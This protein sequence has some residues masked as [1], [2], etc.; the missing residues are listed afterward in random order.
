M[1]TIVDYLNY[2][3]LTCGGG[4][5][6]LGWL[7]R[8]VTDRR[9]VFIAH[10]YMQM[11]NG[12]PRDAMMLAQV[13]Y[14]ADIN[15]E[16][17]KPR[18]S[19]LR[20]DDDGIPHLWIVKS[21]NEWSDEIGFTTSDV[22]R[23]ALDSLS[24][25]KLIVKE[26][27]L[28]PFHNLKPVNHVRLDWP[29]I[30]KLIAELQIPNGKNTDCKTGNIPIDKTG[31]IPIDKTGNIP[32]DKTGNIPVDSSENSSEVLSEVLSEVSSSS[33]PPPTLDDDDDKFI[34]QFE[35]N[36][37]DVSILRE[38]YGSLSKSAGKQLAINRNLTLLTC[39]YALAT[40]VWCNPDG[41]Q[42]VHMPSRYVFGVLKKGHFEAEF[43]KGYSESRL[44][45]I[46]AERDR[47]KKIAAMSAEEIE[48]YYNLPDDET[49]KGNGT[50]VEPE[51][52][53]EE[54]PDYADTY[55]DW[56]QYAKTQ[57]SELRK[58]NRKKR[59]DICEQLRVEVRKAA[60]IAERKKQRI[61]RQKEEKRESEAFDSIVPT[62]AAR[63]EMGRWHSVTA[64]QNMPE[65]FSEL[66]LVDFS[67]K[68]KS[69]FGGLPPR[70][71]AAPVAICKNKDELAV[72]LGHL[73][74]RGEF[75]KVYPGYEIV[76]ALD[77]QKRT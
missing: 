63:N 38:V 71:V 53:I 68:Q 12:Q 21:N 2:V 18:M 35:L 51:P 27:H 26:V 37:N 40:Q 7:Q 11:C 16:T 32:I 31:N 24:D 8:G 5:F 10:I 59:A 57:W 75:K 1:Q 34:K 54:K 47:K 41:K 56:Q 52:V 55:S 77:Y 61:I 43:P 65:L 45:E 30:E 67:V 3:K 64:A 62:E 74:R 33:P 15:P 69:Q 72:L 22:S 48:A 4:D 17:L 19:Y 9:G 13:F 42:Y 39:R 44:L 25:K 50:S 70:L 73:M 20:E 36:N 14:W 29:V 49:V 6:A 66:K 76:S 23:Y 60:E 58:R 28:S 46:I